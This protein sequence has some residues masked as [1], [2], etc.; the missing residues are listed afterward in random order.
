MYN[1]ILFILTAT[2]ITGCGGNNSSG[3]TNNDTLT[4]TFIDSPV[5]GLFYET[6]TFS[7]YTN[8]NGEFNYKSGETITFSLGNMKLGSVNAQSKITPLTLTDENDLNNISAKATG[9][10]RLLQSLDNNSSNGAILS[11]PQSLINLDIKGLD[12]ESD[13]DLNTILTRAQG[14]TSNT[15]TLV[16]ATIAQNRMKK[17]IE[18]ENTYPS[19]KNIYNSNKGTKYYLLN[20]PTESTVILSHFGLNSFEVGIA[21]CGSGCSPKIYDTDMNIKTR[22]NRKLTAGTYIIKVLHDSN[23]NSTFVINYDGL[24][25]NTT[26]QELKNGTFSNTGVKFYTLNM[27]QNGD[28]T[29]NYNSGL[30]GN[31]YP[32]Y[33]YDENL[34]F[35]DYLGGTKTLNAGTYTILF[36]HGATDRTPNTFSVSSNL[37]N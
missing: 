34:D 17:Y 7:G 4:G 26:H 21:L 18:L 2:F 30:A 24:N 37:L 35:V 6:A 13:A 5:K 31:S 22:V 8:E 16:N 15:Y 32:A 3:N 25:K 12:L 33:I 23:E 10:A 27:S 19:I 29:F 36:Y 14:I 20:L 1:I 28:V 9:I 11:I